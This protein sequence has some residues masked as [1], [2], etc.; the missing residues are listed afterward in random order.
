[1][2]RYPSQFDGDTGLGSDHGEQSVD[3]FVSAIGFLDESRKVVIFQKT[4]E[5]GPGISAGENDSH[6]GP[7]IAQHGHDFLPIHVRHLE[8][9][10]DGVDLVGMNAE[11][12]Y[13]FPAVF[14]DESFE[15][16]FLQDALG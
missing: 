4:R 11:E 16:T 8:V 5:L 1:M 13:G 6:L 2:T 3:Q 14:G 9:E 7:Q 10:Q 15:S 12:P